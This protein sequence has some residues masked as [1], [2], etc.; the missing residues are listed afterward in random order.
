MRIP[1][2][3]FL[4]GTTKKQAEKLLAEVSNKTDW[5]KLLAWEQPQHEV[6]LSEYLIGKYPVTNREYQFFVREGGPAPTDWDG[7]Q[8]PPE[9][10]DHPV[11][12]VSWND[13]QAYCQWLS[14]KIGKH[15]R[16]PTEAE[17][18][19]AA[20][21][22]PPAFGREGMPLIYP[23]GN[24]FNLNRCNTVES[25][26]GGTSPVG[27]FS[28]QGDSPY[29]CADMAGNVWEWCADWFDPHEYQNRKLPIANPLGP[30]T[31]SVRVL[32]GGSFLNTRLN[33]RCALRDWYNPN[34]FLD[35]GGFRVAASPTLKSER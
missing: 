9:K 2:G 22:R 32:R 35:N 23:W 10:G 16:L 24:E 21:W 11:V 33:A 34:Y 20:R 15:Y 1:A 12:N 31:G 8:Y 28:P 18:E 6:E 26:I 7:D 29:G 13:A 5:Q 25:N 27:Q 14:Q 3:K 17:W 30:E 19:K 4:M